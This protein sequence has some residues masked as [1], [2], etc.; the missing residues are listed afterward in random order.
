MGR[1]KSLT[2][3]EDCND[4][5]YRIINMP[6]YTTVNPAGYKVMLTQTDEEDLKEAL[7]ILRKENV[8]KGRQQEIEMEL[9]IRNRK[10]STLRKSAWGRRFAKEWEGIRAAAKRRRGR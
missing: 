1:T 4:R 5:V 7:K 2:S 3:I 9:H 6:T 10:D 8:G